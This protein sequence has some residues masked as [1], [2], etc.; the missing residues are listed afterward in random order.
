MKHTKNI[1]TQELAM[2]YE[3]IQE[4]HDNMPNNWE[5][6]IN[7]G[8]YDKKYPDKKFI[9][10]I[11]TKLRTILPKKRRTIIDQ[12]FLRQKYHTFNNDI[13][14]RVYS[15]LTQGLKTNMT[16]T[17]NYFNMDSATTKKRNIDIYHLT[18]KYTIGYCHLR[19]SIRKFRTSRIINAKLTEE[20]YTIPMTFN[21]N[22]Y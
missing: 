3:I 12:D 4:Y 20:G 8:D 15:T 22:N 16:L 9:K 14:E 6:S 21:K 13:N 5:D 11:L 19:K 1:S 10:R 7:Y 2:I 17:I 18:R